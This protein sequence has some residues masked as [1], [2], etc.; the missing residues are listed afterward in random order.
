MLYMHM[1]II[2][3]CFTIY[4]NRITNSMDIVTSILIKINYNEAFCVDYHCHKIICASQT[5]VLINL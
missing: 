3:I 1:Y 5:S 2:H 4:R